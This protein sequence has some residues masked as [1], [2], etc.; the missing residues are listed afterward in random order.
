MIPPTNTNL[1]WILEE[2]VDLVL[3]QDM[4]RHA[5]EDALVAH[6][7]GRVEQPLKAYL[8]PGGREKEFEQ[9]RAIAMQA[10][11]SDVVFGIKWIT[12][13]PKNVE[14]GLSRASSVVILNSIETG[15]PK[16]LIEGATLSHRRTG[17]VAAVAFE[18]L[19]VHD[20]VVAL[21]GAG[22][23]NEEVTLALNALGERVEQFRVFDQNPARAESFFLKMAPKVSRKISISTSLAECL[24]G[25]PNVITATTGSKAYIK[26]HWV[27]DARFLLPLSLDD[28]Q[29][30]TLLSAEK[31]VVDDFNQCN[32]EEK[33]FHHMVRDGRLGREQ[34]YAELGEIVAGAKR[35]RVSCEKIYCNL[36]GMAVEDI[37]VAE[38][39]FQVV[40]RG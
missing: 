14:H 17:A 18:H 4:A 38:A 29:P 1:L 16:T 35:G 23:V 20:G 2:Q 40:S 34:I 26:P 28:F 9:G 37:S 27:H 8:R 3:T 5:V 6:A 22:P 33:L 31:I 39:V 12:S 32:R 10:S 25:A 24:S 21:I 19:G 30:D 36:M 15:F 11:I 13:M 7:E